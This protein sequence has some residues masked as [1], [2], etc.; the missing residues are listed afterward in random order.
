MKHNYW[1]NGWLSVLMVMALSMSA[2][3]QAGLTPI[4]LSKIES[5]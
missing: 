2:F 3:A 4:Q 1:K 5:V